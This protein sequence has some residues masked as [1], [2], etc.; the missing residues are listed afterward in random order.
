M[1]M[2]DTP[3]FGFW[4]EKTLD[5]LTDAEWESLCDGCGK[6]CLNKLQDEDTGEIY[7]TKVACKLLDTKRCQCTDYANRLAQVADCVNLREL[8]RENFHWLPGTCAYRLLW[9]GEDLPDW[10]HLKSGRRSLVHKAICSV[11]GRAISEQDIDPDELEN[12]IIRW[13]DR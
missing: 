7:Y 11:R 8:E 1:I 12:H 10:H 3:Q 6:C 13:V 9:Q 4:L 2:S 5:Q